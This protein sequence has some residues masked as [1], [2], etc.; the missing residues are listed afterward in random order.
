MKR[1]RV[2]REGKGGNESGRKKHN[3]IIEGKGRDQMRRGSEGK[4]MIREK[5]SNNTRKS[6]NPEITREQGRGMVRNVEQK[7]W[8]AKRGS[9]KM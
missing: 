4:R 6:K 5:S 9:N 3:T 8:N 1:N 2:P 7:G